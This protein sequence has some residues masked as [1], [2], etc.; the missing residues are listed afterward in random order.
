MPY[1]VAGARGSRVPIRL[2]CVS[3]PTLGTAPRA[4]SG[5]RG[6]PGI[7]ALLTGRLMR[8]QEAPRRASRHAG[9]SGP[10]VSPQRNACLPALASFLG[11]GWRSGGGLRS[12]RTSLRGR[13]KVSYPSGN[14][15][16]RDCFGANALELDARARVGPSQLGS[17]VY[18]V[19]PPLWTVESRLAGPSHRRRFQLPPRLGLPFVQAV[20]LRVTHRD[21]ADGIAPLRVRF[22]RGPLRV[23][24]T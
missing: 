21:F 24:S 13:S 17:G 7:S 15:G 2:P 10:A 23:Y 5:L 12:P 3:S 18:M 8:P 9:S 14:T 19:P 20:P 1:P 11:D 4:R 16:A 22:R 6:R